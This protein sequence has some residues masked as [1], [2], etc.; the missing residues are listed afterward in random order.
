MLF[1]SQIR[2][3]FCTICILVRLSGVAPID[4]AE[5]ISDD[6][7]SPELLIAVDFA[8]LII[9]CVDAVDLK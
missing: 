3:T 4:W 8:S 9:S 1:S 7:A 2:R 5:T 6:A